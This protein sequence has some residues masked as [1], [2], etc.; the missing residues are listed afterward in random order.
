MFEVHIFEIEVIEDPKTEIRT[1]KCDYEDQSTYEDLDEVRIH[2]P[3]APTLLGPLRTQ[4]ER[5]SSGRHEPVRQLRDHDGK[6]A[7]TRP[8][9][10]R[11][12]DRYERIGSVGAKNH[13]V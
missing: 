2:A 4:R 10:L 1:L 12:R 9:L 8:L 5:R 13:N 7:H 11:S 3:T 6:Q